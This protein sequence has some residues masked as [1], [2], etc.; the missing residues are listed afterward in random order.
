MH[1]QQQSFISQVSAGVP[2]LAGQQGPGVGGDGHHP[3]DGQ[4]QQEASARLPGRHAG[5]VQWSGSVK[6]LGQSPGHPD[7]PR[8]GAALR[9]HPLQLVGLGLNYV[10]GVCVC[11]CVFEPVS[12][13]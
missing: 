13:F 2:P 1:T 11:V 4:G 6:V 7:P 9:H 3:A 10:E 5:G 8:A 12:L